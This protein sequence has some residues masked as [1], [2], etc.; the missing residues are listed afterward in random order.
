MSIPFYAKGRRN[1]GYIKNMEVLAFHDIE[2]SH[3]GQPQLYR[4]TEGKYYLYGNAMRELLILDVTDVTN[5]MLVKKFPLVENTQIYPTSECVKIQVAD[6][7][8]ICAMTSGSGPDFI[9]RPPIDPQKHK[10]LNGVQIYSLKDPEN[11]EFLSYWDNGVPFAMG[12][13]RFMYNGGNYVHLS[14]DAEGF[15]GMIYRI[16]DISNP[17]D[18]H[19]VG[20]WWKPEQYADGYP[21]RTFDPGAKHCPEF[22]DKGWL[23]GPPFVR[24]NYAYL[25]YSGAGLVILDVSDVKRPKCVGQLQFSPL[26]A[27]GLSGAR[28]HTVLP[29]PGRD[30]VVVTNEGERFCWIT[31]EKLAGRAQPMNNLHMVDV[32]DPA[33]PTLVAEFPYPEVPEDFPYP[34][35]NEA[36]LGEQGPFGPHNIH[37]PMSGK[38]WLEQRGDRVYCCYFAAG[39][40]V[41]DVS[42]QYYIKE[43]AY[44]IPPDP[45]PGP[46]PKPGPSMAITEDLVVDDRG[47]IIIC[48][49]GDGLYFLRMTI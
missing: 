37:E 44:F 1:Q 25:G 23:H 11:P 26:F 38:P 7:L 15:E 14:S 21:G 16:L 29:L 45:L 18:P 22:M 9:K 8:L 12:V 34:N 36:W 24:G 30:L 33:H 39:L 40:R 2:G 35:F 6:G 48:T 3:F 19:E 31:H 28:T 17:Y 47:N 41:F 10:A 46:R 20:R 5:P 13:H 32:R 4:T 27:G 49:S 43:L 42:D